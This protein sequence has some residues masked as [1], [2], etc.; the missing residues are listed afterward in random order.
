MTTDNETL[1]DLCSSIVFIHDTLK[2]ERL[3]RGLTQKQLANEMGVSVS[4]ISLL[5]S[6]SN[7]TLLMIK[8]Y[9]LCLKGF[10]IRNKNEK[11][12]P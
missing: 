4:S 5:E 9:L 6:G 2:K 1:D 3:H 11:T 10:D 12:K 7:V 8:K